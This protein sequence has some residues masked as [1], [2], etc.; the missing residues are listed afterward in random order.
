MTAVCTICKE[1]SQEDAEGTP[2]TQT[3]M[4]CSECGQIT[5]PE[6]IK[7]NTSMHA[8]YTVCVL[9]LIH[10]VYKYGTVVLCVLKVPGEGVINK[11]LPS[12]WECPKCV[13]DK[14]TEVGCGVILHYSLAF[15][16]H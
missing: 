11:D 3:L 5:H 16:E 1:G 10:C 6:C 4:E 2:T 9:H 15:Q 12:C 8:L 7:V 14:N 13:H